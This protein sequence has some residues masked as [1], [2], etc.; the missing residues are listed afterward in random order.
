MCQRLAHSRCA[1]R[2]GSLLF[3]FFF[4]FNSGTLPAPPNLHF[5]QDRAKSVPTRNPL[6]RHTSPLGACPVISLP[7]PGLSEGCCSLLPLGGPLHQGQG[8]PQPP[9][10]STIASA[11]QAPLAGTPLP[12]PSRASTPIRRPMELRP[13]QAHVFNYSLQDAAGRTPSP[14]LP[15]GRWLPSSRACSGLPWPPR[16]H[17]FPPKTPQV[18]FW[19]GTDIQQHLAENER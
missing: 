16:L 4:F 13:C 19:G 5:T 1:I 3:L 10:L 8:Q 11:S 15:A 9:A 2:G 12:A 6:R 14:G 18:P 17:T 7:H